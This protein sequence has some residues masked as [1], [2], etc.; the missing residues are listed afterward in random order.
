MIQTDLTIIGSGP[1][2]YQAAAYAA[3]RGLQVVVVEEHN[4]GGTCLNCGCIPTKSLI[5]DAE[6]MPADTSQGAQ[7]FAEAIER[8]DKIVAEMRKGVETLLQHP[9]ITFIEGHAKFLSSTTIQVNDETITSKDII[10]ATGSRAKMPAVAGLGLDELSQNPHVVTSEQLLRLTR[11]PEH[12]CVIGAGVIGLEMASVF[13]SFGSKVTIVEY[14]KECLSTMDAELARRLRKSME[15]RGVK[16]HLGCALQRVDGDRV[17]FLNLKKETSET[18][19]A[20][21][22][23]VATGRQ[24][25]VDGLGLEN[26]MVEVGRTGIVV[27][28]NMQTSVPHIYA[29]GDVNGKQLL[30]HAATFQGYRAVNHMLGVADNIRLD[31]IPAAVFTHPELASVGLTDEQCKQQ[32]I[33]CSTHKA[34]YRA[35]GRAQAAE[36]T[37]GLLKIVC[38]DKDKVIGCHALGHD[39]AWLVQE[40][41]ALMNFD[42]T[43]SRLADIIHVHP[44]LGEIILDAA[45]H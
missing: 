33:V 35:N 5:H 30:A 40:V 43:L 34:V 20:D 4:A 2:G 9:F 23:L 7:H 39:A 29:I 24:A 3:K 10:I 12:L 37:D 21:C 22:V 27:D 15:K 32:A 31:I 11:L 38:D 28:T 13:L 36:V 42:V 6:K 19:Q 45:S 1:G 17:T 18:L 25:N 8:K 16:F 41:S 14:Q 26:T 44:T